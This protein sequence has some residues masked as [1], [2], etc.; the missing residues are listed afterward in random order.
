[1]S[2]SNTEKTVKDIRRN[3]RRKLSTVEKI[4]KALRGAGSPHRPG[5]VAGREFE[6]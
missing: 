6:S 4:P 5:W 1:M 3:A 2:M